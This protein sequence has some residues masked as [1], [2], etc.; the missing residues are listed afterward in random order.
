MRAPL[1]E[2]VAWALENA[3]VRAGFAELVRGAEQEGWNVLVASSGFEELIRPVL[4]REGV[5]VELVAN[6][7]DARPDG[8]RVLWRD[9][10]ICETCGQPCKRSSLPDGEVV[11][12]G[13]GISDRCAALAADRVFATKGLATYLDERGVPFE[14]FDDFFSVANALA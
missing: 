2:V 5:D 14:R 13:D 9:E 3:H 1:E 12:V 7:V 6:R 10:G 11:Y 8:W 4:E